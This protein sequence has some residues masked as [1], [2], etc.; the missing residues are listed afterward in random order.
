ME[1]GSSV[2]QSPIPRKSR[3]R[4]TRSSTD[5]QSHVG[6]YRLRAVDSALGRKIQGCNEKEKKDHRELMRACVDQRTRKWM[7]SRKLFT[8]AAGAVLGVLI[9]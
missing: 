4:E 6:T 9:V 8:T 5:M 1:Y 3:R 2:R 7:W